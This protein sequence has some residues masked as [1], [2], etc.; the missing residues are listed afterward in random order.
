M[1][2]VPNIQFELPN[3]ILNHQSCVNSSNQEHLCKTKQLQV[4]IEIEWIKKTFWN[5]LRRNLMLHLNPVNSQM[6]HPILIITRENRTYVFFICAFSAYRFLANLL[7][8]APRS[9]TTTKLNKHKRKHQYKTE[10]QKND[11]RG[12]TISP[13][14]GHPLPTFRA[15]SDRL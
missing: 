6:F 4:H 12:G 7:P 2:L 10:H 5:F 1:N 14:G 15:C 8:L 9:C 3:R 11:R 13:I